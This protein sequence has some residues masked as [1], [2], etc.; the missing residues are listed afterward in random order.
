ME[1]QHRIKV[2]YSHSTRD[3]ELLRELKEHMS[4]MEQRK[5]IKGWDDGMISPGTAWKDEID[6]NLE[7]ADLILLLVSASF[8]ASLNCQAEVLRALERQKKEGCLV[9]PII[10]RPAHWSET[11][12]AHLQALPTGKVPVTKWGDKD[13]AFVD[14]VEGLYRLTARS[15][16]VIDVH[17]WKVRCE[18]K[19]WI[20]KWI[21]GHRRPAPR[22]RPV[23][24]EETNLQNPPCLLL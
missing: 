8:N 14:I 1:A 10:V 9:V 13:D 11:P 7:N 2:F 17:T 6:V 22:R 16:G 18:P 20:Y 19:I 12:Y 24:Q 23:I 4:V 15:V 3:E 21:V 5:I